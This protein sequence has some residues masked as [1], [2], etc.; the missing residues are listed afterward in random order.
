M[1]GDAL[2]RERGFGHQNLNASTASWGAET[3]LAD[4]SSRLA[5]VESTN[6]RYARIHSRVGQLDRD[7][8]E[9]R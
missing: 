7:V 1:S 3:R 5:K 9:L 2:G 4:V 8:R 6:E